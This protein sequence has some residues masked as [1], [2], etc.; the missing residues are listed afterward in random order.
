MSALDQN[1]DLNGQEK[2]RLFTLYAAPDFVKSANHEDVHGPENL[3][4][5]EFADPLRKL[6]PCHTKAATWASA[7]FFFDNRES[8]PP[9]R[10]A[11]IEDKILKAAEVFNLKDEIETLR[12]S[13]TDSKTD[14]INKLPNEKF[15]YVNETDE[16]VVRKYPL[17]NAAE[18]KAAAEYFFEY[19]DSFPWEAR[20][21]FAR[22]VL[23]AAES[24][25]AAIQDCREELEKSAGFGLCASRDVITAIRQRSRAA[26][27]R[28]D[29]G[30][31]SDELDRL[32]T[33]IEKNSSVVLQKQFDFAQLL[34]DVDR[35]CDWVGR[36]DN[37]FDRPEEVLFGITEKS[38]SE[39]ANRLIGNQLTGNYYQV[40]DLEKLPVNKI[41]EV[42]GQEVA[43]AVSVGG[44]YVDREKLAAVLPTLPRN[45]AKLFDQLAAVCGVSPFAVQAER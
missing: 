3:H 29:L 12:S 42:L 40:D 1:L 14:D 36:Y 15:A 33:T 17:R 11:T 16:G 43:D 28:G 30:G 13:I 25:G 37:D 24:Y 26:S 9:I 45:D 18:T 8:F 44:V 21:H 34:D 2:H 38:A 22:K 19:R 6:Y 27:V 20:N 4:T 5:S 41:A 10:G 39:L 31:L 32:A 23:K 35:R 7:V